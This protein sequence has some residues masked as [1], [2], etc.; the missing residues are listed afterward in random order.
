MN[1]IIEKG[2]VTARGTL[3]G[4]DDVA[5]LNHRLAEIERVT[6]FGMAVGFRT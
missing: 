1:V 4:I 3:Q 2:R 5:C 6:A